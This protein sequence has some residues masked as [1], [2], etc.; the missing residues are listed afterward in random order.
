MMLTAT[1]GFWPIA[2][3]LHGDLVSLSS[4]HDRDQSPVSGLTDKQDTEIPSY[5]SV[6]FF[7]DELKQLPA[8]R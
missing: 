5:V 7:E 4:L 1:Y 6:Y 3:C 2:E 8:D